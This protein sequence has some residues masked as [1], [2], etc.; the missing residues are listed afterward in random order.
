VPHPSLD[1]SF[2]S[3]ESR[4]RTLSFAGRASGLP[5]VAGSW[6][7]SCAVVLSLLLAARADAQE[8]PAPVRTAPQLTAFVAAQAPPGFEDR[9]V[10]VVLEITVETDGTVSAVEVAEPAGDG[11]DEAAVAAA[12]AFVFVPASRDGVPV[13]ARVRYRYLFEPRVVV[14]TATDAGDESAVD[15]EGTEGGAG[16][17]VGADEAAADAS[18]APEAGV[19]A[20]ADGGETELGV[21][22]VVFAP[23]RDGVR[24]TLER[25]VLTTIP[26][27][28]G[29]ALRVVELLPGVGR[30]AFGGGVVLVR[31]AAPGDSEVFLDG[32]PVPL[33]YHFGG[34]TS[35]YNSQ[36]LD[37]IDFVPGNFSVRYG[38]RIGGILEVT[39]RDPRTDGYHG[40]VD[41]NVIDAS[42][43]VEGPI[44]DHFAFAVAARR[45]WV[46]LILG[47]VLPEDGP[48][49]LAAPVYYD[50]QLMLTYRPDDNHRFRLLV[51]GSSDELA[52]VLGGGGNDPNVRGNFGLGTQFHRAQLS[53]LL[54]HEDWFEQEITASVGGSLLDIAVGESTRLDAD[55]I[56]I[57][58]RSEWRVRLGAHTR[59]VGGL[60]LQIT[61]LTLAFRG[62]P[63]GQGEGMPAMPGAARVSFDSGNVT[64]YRPGAYLE[65]QTQLFERLD[66]VVG[67]RADWYREIQAWSI[68]PR[69]T[70]RLRVLDELSVRAAVGLF[71]QPPEFANTTP[72]IG[73]PDL[74]PT[75]AVHVG[76][77]SEL[78]LSEYAL[79]LSV[80]GFYKHIQDRVVATEGGRAPFF[81]NDGLG[82][83]Y[84]VEVG[85]RVNPGGPSP[86]FGFL[87]YTL[88]RSERQ[89]GPDQEWR[90]FDFD[91]TH[92]LSLAAVWN[93][94]DG[95]Q[96]GATFRLVSGNPTTP[97]VGAVNDLSAGIYRPIY[98]PVNS[99]RNPFFHRLDVRVE[100][101]FELGDIGFL[102]LYLDVQNVYNA[103]NREGTSYSFDYTQSNDIPGLPLIPSLGLRG[104]L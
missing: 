6:S 67:I 50:Y 43:M 29:D 83:I 9:T 41:I 92:I 102:T 3:S 11:F 22:A 36:L 78:V 24:R 103:T 86:V 71:S 66:V 55:F 49:F 89:D 23:P 74:S 38:R 28:R 30:P 45:S 62:A 25:E 59:L 5:A 75:R 8:V 64:A 10:A 47:A 73:N 68:D 46:D 65:S 1:P 14:T 53:W 18:E 88:M 54:L 61:P 57:Q 20:P 81:T 97:V 95:W 48:T 56:P 35:F 63:P 99:D 77:G 17:E 72:G 69:L 40:F 19:E 31:G 33:L 85:L 4:G 93:I 7:F 13:R 96:A 39:P 26:G 32:V 27:T 42:L 94:G 52:L 104:E 2:L 76:L 60:D 16:S 44:G 87:S 51:Y 98:G 79:R 15:P 91:Q 84:G 82:R 37:E 101:R 21:E 70:T 12:R 100:K 90:L 58:L 80:D 34:L